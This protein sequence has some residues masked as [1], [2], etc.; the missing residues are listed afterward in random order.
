MFKLKNCENKQTDINIYELNE[1][2]YESLKFFTK[3]KYY[4][5]NILNFLQFVVN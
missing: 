3:Y 5:E 1:I 2:Q 4:T